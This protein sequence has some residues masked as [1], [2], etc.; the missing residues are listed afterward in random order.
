MNTAE[1]YKRKIF[2]KENICPMLLQYSVMRI[3]IDACVKNN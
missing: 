3:R 2:Q 1:M